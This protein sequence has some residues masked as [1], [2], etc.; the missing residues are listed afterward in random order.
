MFHSNRIFRS[1]QLRVPLPSLVLSRGDTRR[2]QISAGNPRHVPL[3][4]D[5]F[6][7]NTFSLRSSRTESNTIIFV[8]SI[9]KKLSFQ[10]GVR[11]VWWLQLQPVKREHLG[12]CVSLVIP[13][14][15]SAPPI[16]HSG[17]I[18][19]FLPS[20]Q[21]T[22]RLREHEEYKA[23]VVILSYTHTHTYFPFWC[24]NLPDTNCLHGYLSF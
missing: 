17:K 20:Q 3:L 11:A 12:K 19:L 16:L 10:Q 2:D 9:W 13:R 23:Y 1:Q 22:K 14:C 21:V 8:S 7:S 6:P 5:T 15:S 24:G 18:P 4:T